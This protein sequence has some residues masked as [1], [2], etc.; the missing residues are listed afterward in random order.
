[1]AL[2]SEKTKEII[3][4]FGGSDKD[5]GST[6]TQIA[7]LTERLGQLNEHFKT[8]KQDHHSRLGLLKIVGQRKKLLRY[9]QKKDSEQYKT[10]IN[11]LGLRK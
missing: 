3:S 7:L 2:Q 9:L 5:S 6:A 8:H 4:K 1:M 11:E 10:V